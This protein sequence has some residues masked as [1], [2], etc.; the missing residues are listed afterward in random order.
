MFIGIYKILYLD[1]TW[2]NS[3]H[4]VNKEWTDSDGTCRS[5]PKGKGSRL[6]VVD[7]GTEEGFVEG[8]TLIFS[9]NKTDDY[10][11]EMDSE[12]NKTRGLCMGWSERR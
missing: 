7:A 12:H 4:T 1:E 6:I 3:G 10:H 2:V 8:A 9:S 11:E 5:L